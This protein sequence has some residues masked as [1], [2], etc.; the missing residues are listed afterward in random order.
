MT[1]T[2][3]VRCGAC[4]YNSEVN[5]FAVELAEARREIDEVKADY[6]EMRQQRD[7]LKLHAELLEARIDAMKPVGPETDPDQIKGDVT[8]VAISPI[9][10]LDD[11]S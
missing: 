6:L 2:V 7:D 9:P 4:G 1:G 11:I 5:T 3:T 10:A 8:V